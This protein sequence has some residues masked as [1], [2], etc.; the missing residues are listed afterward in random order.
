MAKKPAIKAAVK[1]KRPVE[2]LAKPNGEKTPPHRA[3]WELARSLDN[4]LSWARDSW[5]T[6]YPE[7]W[8]A[9]Q[10]REI[11]QVMRAA[12]NATT[13]KLI[14]NKIFE[15]NGKARA[16]ARL[17]QQHPSISTVPVERW[18]IPAYQRDF[19]DL[20]LLQRE[21][22]QI[23]DELEALAVAEKQAPVVS[24]RQIARVRA[25][26]AIVGKSA[27]PRMVL[28][29]MKQDD[30]AGKGMKDQPFYRC[31]KRLTE[32]GE[33]SGYERIRTAKG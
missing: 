9:G 29:R 20:S 32:L 1:A 25:A 26:I 24:G 17:L 11:S 14:G 31:L 4:L 16:F 27:T 3:F 8:L 21:F 19:D 23:A 6:P 10:E 18:T 5:P 28:S 13:D 22:K 30:P 15:A 2:R 33:F 12:R 7:S